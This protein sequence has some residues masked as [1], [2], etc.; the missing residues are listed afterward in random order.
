MIDAWDL[1]YYYRI[2]N[3]R[4]KTYGEV[5]F[6]AWGKQSPVD[7]L[8]LMKWDDMSMHMQAVWENMAACILAEY[9]KRQIEL[10]RQS[11][12]E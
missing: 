9:H 3:M 12:P 5:L 10:S 1:E 8:A 7:T 2:F 11:K 4:Q 6:D